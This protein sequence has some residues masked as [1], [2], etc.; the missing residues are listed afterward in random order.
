MSIRMR[1]HGKSFLSE[2]VGPHRRRWPLDFDIN[3]CVFG[4]LADARLFFHM[5]WSSFV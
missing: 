4:V 5:C 1:I 3:S 2:F